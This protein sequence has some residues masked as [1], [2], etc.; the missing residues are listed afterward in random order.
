MSLAGRAFDD[1]RRRRAGFR[2][3][4]LHNARRNSNH[5][6]TSSINH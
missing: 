5:R 6:F 4:D 1:G 3:V 2:A